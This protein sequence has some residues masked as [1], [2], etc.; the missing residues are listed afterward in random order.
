MTATLRRS[1]AFGSYEQV[2]TSIANQNGANLQPRKIKSFLRDGLPSGSGGGTGLLFR[3]GDG[4]LASSP[5]PYG[6][7][8]SYDDCASAIIKTNRNQRDERR[9]EA[10]QIYETIR[11]SVQI[12]KLAGGTL[13]AERID[14]RERSLGGPATKD[15]RDNFSVA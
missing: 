15:S 7:G 11:Q 5:R 9:R 8:L 2:N 14:L 13:S 1:T 3:T 4:G 6:D 10:R 12:D